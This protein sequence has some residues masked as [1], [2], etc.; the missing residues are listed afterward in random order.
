MSPTRATTGAR[1]HG[2]RGEPALSLTAGPTSATFL[3]DLGMLGVSLRHLDRECLAVDRSLTGYRQGH[4]TGLP[5]LAPWANRLSRWAYRAA[6]V[7]VELRGVDLHVDPNGLPIHGTMTA[8]PGWELVRLTTDGDIAS[9][10]TRFDYDTDELLAAFP[11]PHALTIEATVSPG[12]LCVVTTVVPTGDR[13]VPVSFGYHPYLSL[14]G[15][16]R[17]AWVLALPERHHAELDPR[18]I[19]TG[20]EH[21]EQ[22]ERAPLGARTFDDHYRLG[23]DRRFS[24]E[25]A[26]VRVV[27]E[28]TDGYPYAQLFAPPR[29]PFLCVEPMTAP[30]DA[31]VT[32]DHPTVEP[33]STFRA[34]FTVAVEQL[35]R[36]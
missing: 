21:E 28:F 30:V 23:D 7:D 25:S 13:A 16:A 33:G 1:L 20:V 27:V 26:G 12:R 10:E 8:R 15:G 11:F 24:L 9:V 29:R 36:A 34:G 14:A 32:G 6:G 5:L 35:E 3:P 22:A 17:G 4:V 19:P 18:S 31:L 2:W